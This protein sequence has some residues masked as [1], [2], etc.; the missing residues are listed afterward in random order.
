MTI[1]FICNFLG[2][3]NKRHSNQNSLHLDEYT[4]NVKSV[5][6]SNFNLQIVDCL[7]VL[8]KFASLLQVGAIIKLWIE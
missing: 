4:Y 1:C 8:K 2:Y 5:Y 3:L 6:K 7:K